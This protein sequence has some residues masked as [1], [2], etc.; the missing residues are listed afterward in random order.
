MS[1]WLIHT[2]KYILFVAIG[3]GLLYM[4]YRNVDFQ[5]LQTDIA[6][7]NFG[8]IFLSIVLGYL[9]IVWRAL[10]WQTLIDPLGYQTN[11][12]NRIHAVA[13]SYFANL[14]IPRSGEVA[15]CTALNQTDGIPVD[16]LFG[17][18]IMERV[19]DLL[20]LLV[21]I[22]LT[23]IFHSDAISSF[24]NEALALRKGGPEE[25]FSLFFLLPIVGIGM[26]VGVMMI[27]KRLEKIRIFARAY[28][29]WDGIKDGLKSILKL[30]RTGTFFLYTAGIWACYFLMTYV[31]FFALPATMGLG[32]PDAMLLFVVGGLAMIVPAPGG[33]GSYHF[34]VMMA[35]PALLLTREDGKTFAAIVW[36]AQTLMVIVSGIVGMIMLFL[37]KRKKGKTPHHV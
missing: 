15:R 13:F 25:G 18:V 26:L 32:I 30:Q 10:R 5:K 37:A 12:F 21:M 9:A 14:G 6:S 34:A 8:W 35:F 7:A 1:K 23:F 33:V 31:C 16:K 4:T 20:M 29:F 22:G 36:S 11:P 2:F 27:R 19:I 3:A 17:T 28:A 24:M